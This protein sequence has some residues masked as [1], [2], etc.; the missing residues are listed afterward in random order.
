MSSGPNKETI[1][2]QACEIDDVSQRTEFLEQA[3]QGDELLRAEIEKLLTLDDQ[4]DSLLDFELT[5]LAQMS[6]AFP[7]LEQTGDEIGPSK[8]LQKIGEGGM[9][10]V[11]MAE[12]KEPVRRW[13]ALKIIKPGM[14]TR[15]ITV[16]FEAERQAL[17]M[18]DRPNIAKILDCGATQVGRPYFVME[19]VKGMSVTRYCNEKHL[20]PRERLE[21]FVPICKAI[22]HAHQKGIIHRDI[23]PSN[24]LVTEYDHTFVPKVIDFGVAKALDQQLTGQTCFT[25]YGQIIGTIEYMSPE[26]AKVKQCQFEAQLKLIRF[27][28]MESQIAPK[29]DCTTVLFEM[30]FSQIQSRTTE[31]PLL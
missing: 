20:T 11:Y 29:I 18:M 25:R 24:I 15:D 2:H 9:G 27:S 28:R 21:L 31:D 8:L 4:R 7:I 14:D 26:Q 1:F 23:K 13:V 3:C 22:Q 30:A 10:V 6:E 5:N 12:Q 19:L 17:A 16:R